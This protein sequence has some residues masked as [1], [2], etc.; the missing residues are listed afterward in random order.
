MEA[1]MK[2]C[3]N[4]IE[5]QTSQ[6][7][8]PEKG[9]WECLGLGPRSPTYDQEPFQPEMGEQ[10]PWIPRSVGAKSKAIGNLPSVGAPG[11]GESGGDRKH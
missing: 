5:A 9:R 3:A 10:G 4:P 7:E 6:G 1:E 8:N 2:T 11:S